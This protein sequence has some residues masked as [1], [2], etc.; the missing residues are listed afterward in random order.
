MT[1]GLL[2]TTDLAGHEV[3]RVGMAL[4]GTAEHRSALSSSEEPHRL[5]HKAKVLPDCNAPAYC[6]HTR[7]HCCLHVFG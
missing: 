7:K 3:G 5:L 1:Q 4:N 6:T 2:Y